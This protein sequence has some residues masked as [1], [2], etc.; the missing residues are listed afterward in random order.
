[1][2]KPALLYLILIV[3][4]V[5]ACGNS[6]KAASSWE[7]IVVKT[8]DTSNSLLT[9]LSPE[10]R[11]RVKYAAWL[12][13]TPDSLENIA[14]YRFIDKW[15]NTPYRWG[16]TD[17][18]GIDCSAFMQ[19]LLQ[20]VYNI[21]VPRTSMQQFFTKNVEPF[22]DGHYFAEGDLVFFATVPGKPVSHV[23]FYLQNRVFVNA[24]SSQGVSL[25]NL[26]D[27]YWKKRYVAAGRV[28]KSFN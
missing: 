7:T 18:K 15:M 3:A 28:K 20:D 2:S 9:T 4:L 26:D 1:M 14:L 16:G 22:H 17:E 24:S 10:Q 25:A 11:L 21:P 6:K 12:K 23:G 8:T 5:I 27:P 19:R 13:T